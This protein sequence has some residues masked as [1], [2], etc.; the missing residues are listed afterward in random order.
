MVDQY[1]KLQNV[2]AKVNI[3][4]FTKTILPSVGNDYKKCLKHEHHGHLV[5]CTPRSLPPLGSIRH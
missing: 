3:I 5:L 4:G 2:C 1:E